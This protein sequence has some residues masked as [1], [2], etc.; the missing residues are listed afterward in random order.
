MSMT[1][2]AIAI[3]VQVQTDDF[4]VAEQER[5]LL[6][7]GPQVGAVAA[8]TGYVRQGSNELAVERMELEHYPG[9]TEQSISAI[10][11]EA[12]GRW[13]LLAV[14]VIHRVG[15]LR[16]GE[17]IVYVGV[18]G[19]H[20]GDAFAACE[21]IMDYLKTRAPFWKKEYTEKGECWV[22]AR[23]SDETAAARW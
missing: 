21:F 20:R 12:A 22:E 4:S 18:A 23:Q 5:Q 7:A 14:R 17:R 6:A 11:E 8:F 15:M 19:A 1:A 3:D 10:A 13:P 9:M 2:H 16:T